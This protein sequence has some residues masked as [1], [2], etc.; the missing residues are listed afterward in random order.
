VTGILL[1]VVR[2][3]LARRLA[4]DARHSMIPTGSRERMPLQRRKSAVAR[5]TLSQTFTG[6]DSDGD[7]TMETGHQ[8]S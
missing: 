2:S 3:T 8:V 7:K 1:W 5:S 4:R 6:G